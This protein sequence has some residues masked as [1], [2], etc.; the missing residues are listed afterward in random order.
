MRVEE[1]KDSEGQFK[2]DETKKRKE[3]KNGLHVTIKK[4]NKIKTFS[5]GSVQSSKRLVSQRW[6]MQFECRGPRRFVSP[7]A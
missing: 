7:V 5:P 3:K 1:E 4:Q 6:A 2:D